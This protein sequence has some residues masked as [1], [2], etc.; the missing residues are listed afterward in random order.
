MMS[1]L[2]ITEFVRII[3]FAKV[4]IE[5]S[6]VFEDQLY[7]AIISIVDYLRSRPEI[8]LALDWIKTGRLDLGNEVPPRIYGIINELKVETI[9]TFDQHFIAWIAQWILFMIVNTLALWRSDNDGKYENW[10]KSLAE[11]PNESFRVLFRFIALG[12]EG[13]QG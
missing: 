3:N 9:Q 2:F 6:N 8:L 1:Q 10:E 5:I 13:L 11:L 7:L 4:Q 12:L